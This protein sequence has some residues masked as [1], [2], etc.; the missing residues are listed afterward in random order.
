MLR[1]KGRDTEGKKYRSGNRRKGEVR[2]LR[3]GKKEGE[4]RKKKTR[5]GNR[6]RKKI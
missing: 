5:N 2:E 1:E 6:K 4:K 3:E